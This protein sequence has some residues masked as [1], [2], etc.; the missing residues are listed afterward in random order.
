MGVNLMAPDPHNGLSGTP[1]QTTGQSVNPLARAS[2][3][4]GAALFLLVFAV[5]WPAMNG[6]FVWDDALL[7]TKNPLVLAKLNLLS[8]WFHTDFP[9]TNVALWAQWRLWGNHP[10]GFHLVNQLLH[11]ANC[12]LLWRILLRLKTPGAWLAAA[13][14]AVHPVCVGSVAWIAEMKNTL[15]LLFFLLSLNCFLAAEDGDACSLRPFRSFDSCGAT[16]ENPILDPPQKPGTGGRAKILHTISLA[17]FLLALL[18]K[19]T[20]VMLPVVFLALAAWR[21]RAITRRDWL[22]I[23]PFFLLALIFGCLTIRFQSA[24]IGTAIVQTENFPGR[25]AAAG[26][27]LWFYLGKILFPLRLNLIYPLWKIDA[28]APAAYLPGLLWCGALGLCLRLPR[29]CGLPTFL[30]LSCFTATLFPALG[31]FNMYF[32]TLSRVSDHFQYLP[33]IAVVALVA[34]GLQSH[35]RPKKFKAA[36]AVILLGLSML[37][38][39]RAHAFCN[40]ESLWRDT[41]GKNPAAWTARNNLGCLLAQQGQLDRAMDQFTASLEIN[42]QNADAHCNLARALSLKHDWPGANRHFQA[43]LKIKPTGA[44]I[45]QAYASGL[46]EQGLPEESLAQ[47]QESVRLNPQ[48]DNRL[49]LASLLYERADYAG[50]I[51]HYRKILLLQP[52]SVEVLNNLSWL[53]ATCPDPSVRNGPDAVLLAQEACRITKQQQAGPLGTLAAACAEAGRF[54]DAVDLAGKAAALADA[55]GDRQFSAANRELQSLYR[56]NQAFHQ[57]SPSTAR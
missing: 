28:L 3:T 9:L 14:F 56:S 7:V 42:P 8:I 55:A 17:A 23:T 31:F 48:P 44:D 51:L 54:G 38:W 19:T 32:L 40:E 26:W 37:S 47:L 33:M 35:L 46:L 11:A 27:A 30:A 45:H 25:L 22:Q 29:R 34:A 39:Q 18:S 4:P 41:L 10:L 21:R 13:L 6:Q 53:L 16:A 2:W 15:S 49:Q 43:A 5:Y 36:A 57:P 52:D 12:A 20:T 24:A 50:A 1:P